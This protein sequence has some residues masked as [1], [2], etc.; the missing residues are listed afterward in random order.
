IS[1]ELETRHNSTISETAPI[2]YQTRPR[3]PGRKRHIGCPHRL[4]ADVNSPVRL[5][6]LPAPVGGS[7]SGGRTPPSDDGSRPQRCQDL[8]LFERTPKTLA[9]PDGHTLTGPMACVP[10][11]GWV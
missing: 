8:E 9:I 5:E 2:N 10:A 11:C 4:I 7:G 6:V 1:Q 3:A